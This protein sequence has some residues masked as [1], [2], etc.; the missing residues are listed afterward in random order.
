MLR[1]TLKDKL[2]Y[3]QHGLLNIHEATGL[4]DLDKSQR[5]KFISHISFFSPKT[6]GLA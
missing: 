2:C 5:H 1:S 4:L 6:T 3:Q